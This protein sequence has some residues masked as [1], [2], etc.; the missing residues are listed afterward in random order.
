MFVNRRVRCVGAVGHHDETGE[1][2]PR[3]LVARPIERLAETRRGAVVFQVAR[4][5]QPAGRR[6]EAE[7][8]DDEALRQRGQQL[9]VGPVQLIL[10]ERAARL[11]VAVGDRHAA[12]VVD[13]DAEKVL[14][15]HR[16]LEDQRRPEETDEEHGES[17]DA[18]A[19]QDDAIA[20]TIGGRHA[21]IR[22]QRQ[23][24]HRDAGDDEEQDRPRQAPAEIALLE[25]EGR[26]FEEEAEQPFDHGLSLP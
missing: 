11:T 16:R 15:R 4:F 7:K 20:Q 9:R 12:R 14:L 17:G 2:Q 13:Q 19:D 25:H 8:A 21:A 26:V 10:H 5:L 23:Q 3:Q 6:G 1:R 24:R 18:Q 22:Q